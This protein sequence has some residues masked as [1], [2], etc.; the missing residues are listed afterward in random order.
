M[1]SFLSITK[2][3]KF[4]LLLDTVC[5]SELASRDQKLQELNEKYSSEH[6]VRVKTE[7][8]KD[9]LNVK[10]V[11]SYYPAHYFTH[12]LLFLTTETHWRRINGS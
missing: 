3:F 5:S 4:F 9:K 8:Q 7:K 1:V 10:L 11:S 2:I 6:K 12:N